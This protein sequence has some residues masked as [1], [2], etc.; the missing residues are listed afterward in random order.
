M[1]CRPT[2]PDDKLRRVWTALADER[3]ELGSWVMAFITHD[4]RLMTTDIN[5][6]S[7]DFGRVSDVGGFCATK[8]EQAG[9]PDL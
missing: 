4:Y 5:R 7:S 6:Y 2:L 9:F 3:K 1:P 8:Q